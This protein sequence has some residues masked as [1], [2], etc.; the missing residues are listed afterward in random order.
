MSIVVFISGMGVIDP[1]RFGSTAS[2]FNFFL[3]NQ[4]YKFV[5]DLLGLTIAL[6]VKQPYVPSSERS[7]LLCLE[8]DLTMKNGIDIGGKGGNLPGLIEKESHWEI[9]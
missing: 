2:G 3:L 4:S 1:F 7:Q 9:N 6:E 8:P 5:M